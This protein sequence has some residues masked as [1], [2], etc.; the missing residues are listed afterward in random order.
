M[1]LGGPED[2][3]GVHSSWFLIEQALNP[4]FV[5]LRTRTR[6]SEKYVNPGKNLTI[7]AEIQIMWIK[8]VFPCN[9]SLSASQ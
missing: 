5:S 8:Y 7:F 6:H 4:R 1:G 3:N 9:F 2:S